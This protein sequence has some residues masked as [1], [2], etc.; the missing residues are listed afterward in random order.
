MSNKAFASLPPPLLHSCLAQILEV[1]AVADQ[2][3]ALHRGMQRRH[4]EVWDSHD[5]L[6]LY[7]SSLQFAV[8]LNHKFFAV[9]YDTA[10]A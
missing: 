3:L 6:G 8:S 4:D 2:M 7:C 1:T 10:Q 9:A 5:E